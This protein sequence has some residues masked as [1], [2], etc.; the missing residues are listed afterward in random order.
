MN[1]I[2]AARRPKGRREASAVVY[3]S[4]T[5]GNPLGHMQSLTR[6]KAIAFC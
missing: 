4:E 2:Q 1:S 5:V 3:R 6:L